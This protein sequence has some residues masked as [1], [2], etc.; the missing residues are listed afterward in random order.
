MSGLLKEKDS[1]KSDLCNHLKI[2]SEYAKE[3]GI[4][5]VTLTIYLPVGVLIDQDSLE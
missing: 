1:F 3:E 2:L 5:Q 4:E